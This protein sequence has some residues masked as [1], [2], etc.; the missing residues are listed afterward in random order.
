VE[1]MNFEQLK[2]KLKTLLGQCE[3]QK[4]A[5]TALKFLPLLQSKL[6]YNQTLEMFK[7]IPESVLQN[8]FVLARVYSEIV[9]VVGD[10][11]SLKN[12]L[13]TTCF[14]KRQNA[15]LQ[16]Q[17]GFALQDKNLHSEAINI[18]R[19]ALEQVEHENLG[20]THI[21]L[22]WSLFELQ[23]PW[24][25]EFQKGLPLLSGL[26]LARGL[27]NYGYCLSGAGQ[28]PEAKNAWLKTLPLVKHR[29]K[30][31]AYVLFNLANLAQRL[32]KPEAEDY[33]LELLWLTNNPKA[34]DRR[35]AALNG[36]GVQRRIF[37][38]WSRAETAY[39]EAKK[40]AA[41]TGATADLLTAYWGLARVY[42][43]SSHPA[44]AQALLEEALLN[45]Q[46]PQDQLLVAKASALLA[47]N[48]LQGA[49]TCLEQAGDIT[50]DSVRWLLAFAKA[51]IARREERFSEA[52]AHLQGLPVHTLHAREEAGRY[53]KLMALLEIDGKPV[54][55]PLEYVQGLH[56]SVQ[57]THTLKVSINKRPIKLPPTGKIAELLVYLLEHGGTADI[58]SLMDILYPQQPVEK[59]RKRLWDLAQ[60]LEQ[61]LGWKGSVQ[62]LFKVYQL[63]P[64][65]TWEYDIDAAREKGYFRGSFLKGIDN[66]WVD[67]VRETLAKYNPDAPKE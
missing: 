4:F 62:N 23:K 57:A 13:D 7:D 27:I 52:V 12:F 65:A 55:T 29:A 22:G 18:F 36:I 3:Y 31:K 15:I 9:S 46:L 61:T 39:L 43:L 44:Q 40:Y 48:D 25:N 53:P 64:N 33:W 45:S 19:Q 58:S 17:Y 63:D 21:H 8:N 37:G 16:L 54:P 38:E 41:K 56:I 50:V 42:V 47:Q 51:E 60:L 35:A 14:S 24:E 11:T 1:K 20:V 26:E 10:I 30:T 5:E 2:D 59:A 6:E 28:Y 49:K 32:M 66:G 67:D 34:A